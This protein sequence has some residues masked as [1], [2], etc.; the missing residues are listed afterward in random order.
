MRRKS[1][2]AD[3]P[4]VK[5]T[6]FRLNDDPKAFLHPLAL[7]QDRNLSRKPLQKSIKRTE[8]RKQ[9]NVRVCNPSFQL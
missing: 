4:M 8:K 3:K 6:P 7:S 5:N 2:V 9:R 1:E